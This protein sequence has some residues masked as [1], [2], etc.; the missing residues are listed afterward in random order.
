MF[1]SSTSPKAL[2]GLAGAVALLQEPQEHG[3]SSALSLSLSTALSGTLCPMALWFFREYSAQPPPPGCFPRCVSSSLLSQQG[4]MHAVRVVYLGQER[5]IAWKLEGTAQ[6]S[7]AKAKCRP[8]FSVGIS[9]DVGGKIVTVWP[10]AVV[11]PLRQPRAGVA[12][13]WRCALTC[14]T[15][16][17]R[18][19]WAPGQLCCELRV[20]RAGPCPVGVRWISRCWVDLLFCSASSLL[21]ISPAPA[22]GSLYQ[23]HWSPRPLPG[24]LSHP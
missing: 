11:V 3:H 2:P 5:G 18:H 21:G 22:P 24:L 15:V 10:E 9:F 20:L 4:W 8:S 17:L 1:W 13:G 14:R 16:R 7:E 6:G 23:C 19:V 12:V